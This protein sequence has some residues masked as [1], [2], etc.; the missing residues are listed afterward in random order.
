MAS[1]PKDDRARRT[2]TT[3]CPAPTRSHWRRL[4]VRAVIGAVVIVVALAGCDVHPPDRRQQANQLTERVRAL[5]AVVSA[6]NDL[7]DSFSQGLVYLELHVEVADDV[8]GDQLAAIASAYLD[9]LRTEDYSGYRTEFDAQRG[10]STFTIDGG[11][12]P[13][14]NGEQIS[15]QARDWVSL[16]HAFP[17]SAITL[18]ATITHPPDKTTGTDQS[19]PSVGH[20]RLSDSAAYPE[21]TAAFS[22]LAATVPELAD[23]NWTVEAGREHPSQITTSRRWPNDAELSVW[24]TLNADQAIPH[25]DAM[26]VN[27]ALTGPMWVAEKT[28]SHYSDVALRLAGEHLPIVATLPAPVLYTANDAWSGHLD[29][30][31]RATQSA[32]ITLGGCTRRTYPPPPAE[33]TLIDS[34]ESCRR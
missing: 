3:R 20:I 31:A 4:V 2:G 7:A 17:G 21:V 10:A 24:R 27:D 12:A 9:H 32:A 1:P 33:R 15:R 5:P 14:S 26:T 29:Y 23:G 11:R 16:R 34:Y 30:A 19:H 25:L 6:T 22:T 18:G 28:Q 13:I 8:T